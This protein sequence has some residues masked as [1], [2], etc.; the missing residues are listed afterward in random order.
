MEGLEILAHEGRRAGHQQNGVAAKQPLG[1]A[2]RL[3]DAARPQQQAVHVQAF[4]DDGRV[5]G[6][7][8]LGPVGKRQHFEIS[9]DDEVG[10]GDPA[11]LG[12]QRQ[13]GPADR[14]ESLGK[15]AILGGAEI[16]GHDIAKSRSRTFGAP[17]AGKRNLGAAGAQHHD[18]PAY[19]RVEQI[20]HEIE[21]MQHGKSPAARLHRR[22]QNG[23]TVSTRSA[24]RRVAET[25]IQDRF[26]VVRVGLAIMGPATLFR[27]RPPRRLLALL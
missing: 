22:Q 4:V 23:R 5:G 20:M 10:L 24:R 17:E 8:R 15:P 19:R 18:A 13:R 7:Q 25:Q 6:K 14:D 3:A 16:D 12:A 21:N 11:Q 9:A 1:G 27:P 2:H 26:C